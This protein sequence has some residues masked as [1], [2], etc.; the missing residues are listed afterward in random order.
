MSVKYDD[1]FYNHYQQKEFEL[2]PHYSKHE[3]F[4]M[5]F[6]ACFEHHEFVE[7][8]TIVALF[9]EGSGVFQRNGQ[10]L[11]VE[12]DSFFVLNPNEGWEFFNEENSYMDVLSFGI[13]KDFSSSFSYYLKTKN[14]SILD[15]PFD[16]IKDMNFFLEKP[17][18]SD[19]Y[20]SGKLLK[21][22]YDLSND[23]EFEFLCPEE[24]TI[25]VLQ[26]IY[27]E[28]LLGNK[29]V[30]NIKAKKISTKEETLKRLLIAYEFIHD[31]IQ[32]HISINELS[33]ISSLSKFHLYDSFKKA[34]GKTPHQYIN[35]L[36]ISKAKEALQ[37]KDLSVS[38][39]SDFFGFSDL[40]VFSKVFKKAYGNPP[41]YYLENN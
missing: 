19:Y 8:A 16:S 38:E 31:N 32:N 25:E 22:I 15:D 36:K 1:K 41:S 4:L 39:I 5:R 6:K 3:N 34:F 28:Q 26:S 21:Y 13:T 37:K 33:Y 35:R 29:I 12:K 18:F 23:Y 2:P 11:N 27:K 40:S 17:L 9:K 24:L 14:E 30:N 20:S 7:N 10:R